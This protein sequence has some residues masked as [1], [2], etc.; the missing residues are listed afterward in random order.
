MTADQVKA[1][2]LSEI[3]YKPELITELSDKTT[4]GFKISYKHE[5]SLGWQK[6]SIKVSTIQLNECIAYYEKYNP[7]LLMLPFNGLRE[8]VGS[9]GHSQADFKKVY[10]QYQYLSCKLYKE[11]IDDKG[12]SLN[13]MAMLMQKYNAALNAS[14]E[15]LMASGDKSIPVPVTKQSKDNWDYW[16]G[17]INELDRMGYITLIEYS[18]AN[19]IK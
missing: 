1:F 8:M 11:F 9:F 14:E 3:P 17:F 10:K 15:H 13:E 2:Y 5:G 12:N 6:Y 7:D 18:T 19:V 16:L 4:E